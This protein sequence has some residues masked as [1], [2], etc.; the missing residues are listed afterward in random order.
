[1]FGVGLI[2]A[3]PSATILALADPTDADGDGISGRANM[4]FPP[5]FV[6][7]HATRS[8]T[9]RRRRRSSRR[10]AWPIRSCLR[11]RCSP[12]WR[13]CACWPRLLPDR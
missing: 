4:V 2:E 7:A 3:I 1:V 9:R 10:I 8:S 5:D 11:A 12:W 6:P 13:T